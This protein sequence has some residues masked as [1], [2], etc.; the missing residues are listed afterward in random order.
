NPSLPLSHL[1]PV[2]LPFPPSPSLSLSLSFPLS[3][4]LSLSPIIKTDST[5]DQTC[6]C[7]SLIDLNLKHLWLSSHAQ[8]LGVCVCV[9]V[10]GCVVVCVVCVCVCVCVCKC[11][12]V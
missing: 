12:C 4:C 1:S 3:L 2:K 5:I 7:P 6:V 9:C 11:A 8:Q 10:C